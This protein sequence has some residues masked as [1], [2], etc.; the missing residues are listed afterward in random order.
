[1]K[2]VKGEIL[3]PGGFKK[4]Y[5]GFEKSIIVE[6]GKDLPGEKPAAEGLI[7]P[8]F[9]NAHTH[10]G[11]SFIRKKNIKLPR[12]VEELVA[13]P[14]SI[15]HRLLK[16]AT[17][18]EIIDGIEDSLQVMINTGVS[19]FCDFREGG[20]NGIHQ[21]T[22]AIKDKHIDS[23]ILSRPKEI[24]YNKSEIDLLLQNSDGIGMS[25]I[26]DG[27]YSELEKIADHVKKKK[28][29]FALH[30]S[31]VF[32]ENIDLIL[33]LKPDFLVHMIKATKSD[34]ACVKDNNIPVVICPSSNAFFG[35]KS[36]LKLMKQIGIDLMLGTD[37]AMLNPPN[38]LDEL[39][40]LKNNTRELSIE[41]LLK[42]ITYVPRKVLNLNCDIL[43]PNSLSNFVVLDKKSLEPLY[44]STHK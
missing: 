4:G 10:L 31:E 42:M 32:R 23:V 44:I 29:I 12:N 38:I 41:E 24:K 39:K 17:D 27:K 26:S 7:V 36:N 16:N 21:L 19:H 28:K 2:Y 9:V 20:I 22:N 13:P 35:L 1:M 40:Y 37:N 33:D 15:K 14:H 8:T 6:V 30:G 11:D 5:L 3:G 43:V 18:K 34:L 25:S